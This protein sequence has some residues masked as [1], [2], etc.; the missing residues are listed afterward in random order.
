VTLKDASV[1]GRLDEVAAAPAPTTGV[2]ILVR[3]TLGDPVKVDVQR[4]GS[5]HLDHAPVGT[6]EVEVIAHVQSNVKGRFDRYDESHL[7]FDLEPGENV[8][9]IQT[10]ISA[11]ETMVRWISLL[12]DGRMATAL[13]AGRLYHHPAARKYGCAPLEYARDVVSSSAQGVLDTDF[14]VLRATT[15]RRWTFAAGGKKYRYRNAAEMA[16]RLRYPFGA[17]TSTV[18]AV[19]LGELWKTFPICAGES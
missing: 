14:Q 5:F 18:H 2:Q 9:E 13:R 10:P 15:L 1:T 7:S 6:A 19:R 4:D 8:M 12:E 16:V 11:V 3:P 17:R